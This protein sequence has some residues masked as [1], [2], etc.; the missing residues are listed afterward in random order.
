VPEVENPAPWPLFAAVVGVLA[1]L[2]ALPLIIGA[3]RANAPAS[4]GGRARGGGK[5]RVK[6]KERPR[7]KLK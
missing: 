7:I 3:V 2:V 1:L 6:M 5:S 4:A